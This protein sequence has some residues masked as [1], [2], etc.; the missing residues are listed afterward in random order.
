MFKHVLIPTDGS[1]L[2]G[3]AVQGGV[4]LAKALGAR[5]TFV[6]VIEPFHILTANVAQI[7]ET[8]A[9]YETHAEVHA[10]E[11]LGQC[12]A[13]ARAAAVE[14]SSVQHSHDEPHRAILHT[15]AAQGCDLIAMSSR[16]RRGLAAAILGSQ[17][18]RVLAD[19]KIPVIVYR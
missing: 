19:A 17:T 4:A 6:V 11:V 13:V 3:K 18:M 12:E 10:A 5:V 9:S 16:G 7:E 1:E 14:S 2:A 15:A 8:R